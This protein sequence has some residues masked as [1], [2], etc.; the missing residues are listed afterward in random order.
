[1]EHAFE[2]LT[3]DDLRLLLEKANTVIYSK[4]EE[5]LVEGTQRQAIFMIRNGLV[6][7]ER[8]H[9]DRNIAFAR[10]GPGDVFGEMAF[11]ESSGASASIISDEDEVEIDVVE[12]SHVYSLLNSVPGLAARFYQSL[13]V[14]LS[15]RLRETS[16]LIPLHINRL[17]TQRM[18]FFEQ[19]SIPQDLENA[20]EQLK[21][22]MLSFRHSFDDENASEYDFKD[23][24]FDACNAFKSSLHQSMYA[25]ESEA[26]KSIGAYIFRETF[27]F[28]MLSYR[29]E[30]FYTRPRD[31]S[32]DYE[33]IKLFYEGKPKGDGPL[34]NL[35]D[36]WL[37]SM[38][39][40]QAIKNMRELMSRKIIEIEKVWEKTSP[41]PVTS[42][43][44]GPALE[45]LDLFSRS[46]TPNI[47]A[48]CIDIDNKALSFAANIVK[49][50]GVVDRMFFSHEN[51]IKLA[52][53]KTDIA[54]FPQQL[55]YCTGL[56][57]YLTDE[58]AVK[59]LNWIYDHLLEGGQCI[60]GNFFDGNRDREFFNHIMEW[61]LIHRSEENIKHLFN[62][63]K[64]NG[65][66]VI[67]EKEQTGTILFA[68]CIK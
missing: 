13:A 45:I 44:S 68:T 7:V 39:T 18:G 9:M 64:F 30:R 35:I 66:S 15:H 32:G 6:R 43:A 61:E 37:L 42:L 2:Y 10:L 19:Q 11:L 20:V 50:L 29:I 40:V 58:E 65:K 28:F 23:K 56:L 49:K 33:M 16:A 5:I 51:V 24:V 34:G 27:P 53:K 4:D 22:S 62:Q 55:I 63:S 47:Q 17:H 48:T 59:I 36:Q 26:A 31:Y 38:N 67:L 25:L 3:Q 52:R 12:G 1:M 54:L 41:L 57:E 8:S 60:V 46:E 21:K 14:T